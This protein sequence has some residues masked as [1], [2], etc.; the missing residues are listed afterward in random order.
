V[1]IDTPDA[2]K[3]S[4]GKDRVQIST[5]DDQA[6]VRSLHE[7]FGLDAGVHEGLVTFSVES[8]EHF[9]P[10]LFASLPVAIKSV[11]VSRPSL[12]D[13]FMSYTGKTIRDAE[14]TVGDRNR[15]LAA[16]M[17]RR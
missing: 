4:I 16:R 15:N 9:V 11:S 1:A 17:G 10:Q 14:A 2:L 7:V 3:A 13:V 8:G 12:D 5:A 6:A